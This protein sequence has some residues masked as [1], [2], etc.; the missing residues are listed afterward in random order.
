MGENQRKIDEKGITLIAL[1]ITIVVLI[2]LAGVGI[3]MLSGEN[4]IL[5]QTQIAKNKTKIAQKEE[6]GALENYEQYIEGSTNGGTLTK[7]IGNE[8]ENTKVHDSLVNTIYIPAGFKVKNLG[9]NVEDG[10][11]I[12]D[13]DE[14]RATY[15]SE[16]VWIYDK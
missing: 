14:T 15:G 8:T 11:I 10:I 16:F 7:V 3:N 2:I 6:E 13:D 9:D 1:V 4:G 12:I 5:M